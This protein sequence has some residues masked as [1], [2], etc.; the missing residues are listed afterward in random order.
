MNKK[1]MLSKRKSKKFVSSY[2]DKIF[3]SLAELLKYESEIEAKLEQ[4]EKKERNIPYK[5]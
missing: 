3:D 1:E 5:E 2:G 4:E